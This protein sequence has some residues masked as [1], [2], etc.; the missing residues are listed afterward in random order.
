MGGASVPDSGGGKHRLDFE[1]NLVPMIDLL[2][3]CI[4]FLI[5]TAAWTQLARLETSQ[6]LEGAGGGGGG[7]QEDKLQLVVFDWGYE[8]L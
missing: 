1:I 2:S 4:S 6:K 8:I 3:C 7:E 5:I